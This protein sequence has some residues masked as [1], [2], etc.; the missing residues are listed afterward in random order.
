MNNAY[1][2]SRAAALGLLALLACAGTGSAKIVHTDQA[3]TPESIIRDWPR[4]AKHTAMFMLDKYGAPSQF[5]RKTLVWFNNGAWKKTIVFRSPVGGEGRNF[6]QQSIGYLVPD[7]KVSELKRFNPNID[8]S[9]TAGELT[10]TSNS[11][12]SNRL[13]LNLADEIVTG[14][15]TAADARGFFRKTSRLAAS[16]KSSPYLE[17]LMFEVDN[18]RFMTPTGADQ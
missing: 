14:K 9:Q 8:V 17:G 2:T 5:D 4:H 11:E 6:L 16:G 18:T 13:A 1:R 7:D 10:F 12:A 3:G 15:R